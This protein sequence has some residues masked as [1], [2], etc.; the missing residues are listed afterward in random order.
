MHLSLLLAGLLASACSP[1]VQESDRQSEVGVVSHIKVL[2]DHVPDVSSMEAWKNSFIRDGMSDEEKALTVWKSCATFQHQENPP[3]EFLQAENYVQDPI[4][5]FNVYGYGFCGMTSC[6]VEALSRYVGLR[7]RGWGINCHSVPEVY[8]DGAWHLLDA[9]LINYFPK[10]D[11]KIAGVEEIMAAINDWYAKNPGYKGND[12]KL[13][14][15]HRADGWTG[16]KKGPELLAR[17]PLIDP[18]GWWSARTHGWYS[19]MQEYDGT[20][21]SGGK[22]F[23]YEY[24]YSRGYEVN[25]QL[26]KGERLT[27]NWSNKGLHINMDGGGAAPGC[28]SEKVGRGNLIYTPKFGD[29]APGRIGNGVLVYEVPIADEGYRRGALQA[30]NLAAP[31]QVKDPAQPGVLV[32][33]MPSSYVYLGGELAL[34]CRVAPGGQIA[35]ALSDN[36]GLDWKDVGRLAESGER[37]IDLKP[38]VF[39]R[40][41]YRLKFTLKGQGT[42]LGAIKIV[43]DIQH[44]QRPLPALV[45]GK[46]M[47]SFS[48]GAPEGTIVIEGCTKAES[49]TRQLIVEDFHPQMKGITASP[50][51][52]EG[53]A[54][55]L[56]FPVSTPGD[57]KRLR[58]GCHYRALAPKAGWDLD[59]SFD[60]GATWKTAGRASGPTP[61]YC[62]DVVFSEIPPGT[63]EAWVR[64]SGTSFRNATVLYGFRINADY[65]EPCGGWSP[66]KVTYR[67]EEE[68]KAKEYV[69]VART[70]EATFTIDC[71]AKPVMTS[72]ILERGE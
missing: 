65:L 31:L 6:D 63:R 51:R 21:S 35:I 62:T 15:F 42:G 5:I 20:Y 27:R 46:N 33:R 39:R 67:W 29:L 54:G 3:N 13:R 49:R 44:S 52:V 14:E 9:S 8:W 17:S 45:E 70:S 26:R 72:L 48:A 66:I 43:H 57:L 34:A 64:Y 41:D 1:Q 4:K 23:V 50:P 22:P 25:V 37:K 71:A 68:G 10:A 56:V 16:W 36:N 32:L 19:T 18:S 7:A 58:F 30:D 53:D 61:G 55:E 40:Y 24:G 28:L 59:V 38:W 47:I 12:A 11:G 2:S 69:F 60:H